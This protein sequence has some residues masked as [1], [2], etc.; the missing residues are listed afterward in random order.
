M[1]RQKSQWESYCNR[2]ALWQLN[3]TQMHWLR[4]KWWHTL[5]KIHNKHQLR[6]WENVVH[7]R[8]YDILYIL[9]SVTPHLS[10]LPARYG[11][12]HLQF[13]S[14][15]GQRITPEICA[16]WGQGRT[17]GDINPDSWESRVT[18]DNCEV[19]FWVR[20]KRGSPAGQGQGRVEILMQN[21]K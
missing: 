7:R 15:V 10:V 6:R 4:S 14:K 11:S 1:L 18:W 17:V 2:T 21:R 13:G 16:V 8:L 19:R 12:C 20:A 9:W 5:I 3:P